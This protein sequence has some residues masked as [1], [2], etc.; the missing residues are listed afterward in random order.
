MAVAVVFGGR[1][2]IVLRL[3]IA[4]DRIAA[5]EAVADPERIARFDVAPLDS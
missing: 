1:L 3:K 2:R 5:I 4:G